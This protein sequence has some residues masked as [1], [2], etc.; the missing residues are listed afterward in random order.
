MADIQFEIV[1]KIGV[2]SQS[3]SGWE[4]ALN[5]ISWNGREARRGC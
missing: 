4:K 1:K 5:L 2:L 3:G